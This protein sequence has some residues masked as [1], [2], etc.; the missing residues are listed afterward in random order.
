MAEVGTVRD[1]PCVQDSLG[2]RAGAYCLHDCV[3]VDWVSGPGVG[4]N[5]VRLN[6]KNSSTPRESRFFGVSYLDHVCGKD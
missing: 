2:G 6:R 1:E 4:G 3:G 5:R